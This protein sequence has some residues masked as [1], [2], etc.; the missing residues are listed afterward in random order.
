MPARRGG[1]FASLCFP[2]S[3]SL[4]ICHSPLRFVPVRSMTPALCNAVVMRLT[5]AI[6]TPSAS[7]KAFC[8]TLGFSRITWRSLSSIDSS[9]K[10]F[11]VF[12]K[13]SFT[14]SFVDSSAIASADSAASKE[15]SCCPALTFS[16]RGSA[17]PSSREIASALRS[18][19]DS[20]SSFNSGAGSR[21]DS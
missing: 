4:R 2:P 15:S 12:S 1:F 11:T 5:V 9:D 7:F 19:R 3:Q 8:V 14:V 20:S 18:A 13:T 16:S 17:G 21:S 6:D 10:T